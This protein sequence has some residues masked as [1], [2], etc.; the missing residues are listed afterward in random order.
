[1]DILL[2][3]YFFVQKLSVLT[4]LSISLGE[5]IIVATEKQGSLISGQDYHPV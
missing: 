5:S 1:M 4:V 2:P 3:F